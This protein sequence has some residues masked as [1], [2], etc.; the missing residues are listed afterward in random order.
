LTR[1]EL[2][3]KVKEIQSVATVEAK[4]EVADLESDKE[5]DLD[6]VTG[7]SSWNGARISKVENPNRK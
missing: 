4:E 3:S 5:P 1:E 2:V 7:S 6:D